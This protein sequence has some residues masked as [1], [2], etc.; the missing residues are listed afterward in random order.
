MNV[1]G[2]EIDQSI[3]DRAAGWFPPDRS[4]TYSELSGALIRLGA[5]QAVSDRVAD[6][7]LQKWRKAGTHAYSGGKWKRRQPSL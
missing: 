1:L 6:R 4:F 5:P 2:H 7:L 3:L